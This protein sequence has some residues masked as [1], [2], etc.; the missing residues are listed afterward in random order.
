MRER[1]G[2]FISTMLLIMMCVI[3]AYWVVSG[4]DLQNAFLYASC[5]TAIAYVS[6]VIISFIVGKAG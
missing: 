3:F 4:V 6:I 5:S 1:E 2:K